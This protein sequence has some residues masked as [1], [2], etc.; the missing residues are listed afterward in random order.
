[1]VSDLWEVGNALRRATQYTT[2]RSIAQ[3]NY[4]GIQVTNG[5]AIVSRLL[6]KHCIL[7]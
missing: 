3:V 7:E 6:D 2:C 5:L 1:M 4:A